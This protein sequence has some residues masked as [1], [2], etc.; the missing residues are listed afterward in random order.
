MSEGENYIDEL[1]RKMKRVEQL[2]YKMQKMT[3]EA[4]ND[5]EYIK[6]LKDKNTQIE[7]QLFEVHKEKRLMEV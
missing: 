4:E 2:E 3:N 5:R 6:H 7:K 1:K